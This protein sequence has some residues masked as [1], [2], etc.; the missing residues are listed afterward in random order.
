MLQC[1]RTDKNVR[2]A[3]GGRLPSH[4]NQETHIAL[5]S[6]HNTH[7]THIGHYGS[8]CQSFIHIILLQYTSC[9]AST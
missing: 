8:L 1:T 5:Y 7:V 3:Q 9:F 2:V 6:H 4:V